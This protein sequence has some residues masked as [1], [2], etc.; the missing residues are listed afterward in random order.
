MHIRCCI[1]FI[2]PGGVNSAA[3]TAKV[4]EARGGLASSERQGI[5][6]RGRMSNEQG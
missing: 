6:V 1:L 2:Y 5:S 3:S 4:Q